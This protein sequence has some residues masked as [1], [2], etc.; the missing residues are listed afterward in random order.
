MRQST[1]A[2]GPALCPC[3]PFRARLAGRDS[4]FDSAVRWIEGNSQ[5]SITLASL[6]GALAMSPYH[7][8]R[9]F[10]AVAGVTPY[11]FILAHRLRRAGRAPRPHVRPAG[12]F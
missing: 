9:T 10:R 3:L 2:L 4:R 6:A 7:F 12:T 5:A 8:L 11:Q 1:W